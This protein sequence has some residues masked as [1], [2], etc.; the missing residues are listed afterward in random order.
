MANYVYEGAG[1]AVDPVCGL[2]HPGDVR[3][4]EQEPD[5]PPWRLLSEALVSASVTALEA[6]G[7]TEEAA[8]VKAAARPAETAP[9]DASGGM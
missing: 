5:C 3:Q 4:F 7:A 9:D 1:P 6:A 8:A 2:V